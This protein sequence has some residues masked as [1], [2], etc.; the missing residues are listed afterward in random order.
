MNASQKYKMFFSLQTIDC[1]KFSKLYSVV[2]ITLIHEDKMAKSRFYYKKISLYSFSTKEKVGGIPSLR[3]GM[4][5][6]VISIYPPFFYYAT[7]PLFYE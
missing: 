3:S 6:L 7:Y 5:S 4:L 2:E 1:E